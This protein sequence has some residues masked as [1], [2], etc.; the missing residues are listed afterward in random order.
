MRYTILPGHTVEVYSPTGDRVELPLE[1][2]VERESIGQHVLELRV[3]LLPGDTLAYETET[4]TGLTTRV[5][6][7]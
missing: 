1:T 4:T 7:F 2:V 3:H 6:R 5:V